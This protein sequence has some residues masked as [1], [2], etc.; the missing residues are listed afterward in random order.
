MHKE[1]CTVGFVMSGRGLNMSVVIYNSGLLS[2]ST[3]PVRVMW[4]RRPVMSVTPASA[5]AVS[6]IML[7]LAVAA[8]LKRPLGRC[9]ERAETRNRPRWH[10]C[11]REESEVGGE[12]P[13]GLLPCI[14]WTGLPIGR[15]CGG[16]FQTGLWSVTVGP[17]TFSSNSAKTTG[18]RWF[19]GLFDKRLLYF[20]QCN[21][22]LGSFIIIPPLPF[23]SDSPS[24]QRS[25]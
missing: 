18:L 14:S 8:T 5:G 10:G 16:W 6:L 7:S 25:S 20:S 12:H 24:W 23:I 17:L 3:A 9:E 21:S 4:R 11:K 22:G 2:T 19:K 13:R 15:V 1:N